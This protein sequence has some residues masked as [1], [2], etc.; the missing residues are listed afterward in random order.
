MAVV[1]V[2]RE[3]VMGEASGPQTHTHVSRWQRCEE[4][5]EEEE[6]EAHT[7]QPHL[8]VLSGCHATTRIHRHTHRNPHNCRARGVCCR[9]RTV[10]FC[11][12]RMVE[13]VLKLHTLIMENR[14]RPV[15]RSDLGLFSDGEKLL[16]WPQF[17]LP[18]H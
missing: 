17:L 7:W 1:V 9:I 13:T 2:S 18:A 12:R 14:P 5:E 4:E 11:V 10:V 16:F 15:L 6:V 3:G 8:G